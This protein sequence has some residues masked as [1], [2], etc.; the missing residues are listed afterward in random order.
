MSAS[1]HLGLM[2]VHAFY[3]L[4]QLVPV[5]VLHAVLREMTSL[6]TLRVF[7]A[8]RA[9]FVDPH[10]MGSSPPLVRVRHQCEILARDF[11]PR[12]LG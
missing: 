4:P 3:V 10:G 11:Y 5:S 6:R 8:Q 12:S 2:L 9:M 7:E 1:L